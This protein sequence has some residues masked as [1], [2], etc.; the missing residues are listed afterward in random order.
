MG[1]FSSNEKEG[2]K[3]SG[4]VNS[5]TALTTSINGVSRT[6]NGSP[7]GLVGRNRQ[8]EIPGFTPNELYDGGIIP[9]K[10]NSKAGYSNDSWFGVLLKNH[11]DYSGDLDPNFKSISTSD[12]FDGSKSYPNFKDNTPDPSRFYST[13]D[14]YLLFNDTSTDYFK[15]GLHIID[16]LT[17]HRSEKN[18]RETWDGGE[19]GTPLRLSQFKGTPYENNDPVIFGFEIVIDA[20]S[21]PLL[22]GAVE[23]F[24]EQFNRIS[25]VAARKLVIADFKQQFSKIFKTRG[26]I[27]G[28]PIPPDRK[29]MSIPTANYA[30]TDS[31]TNI[32][33]PGKKAYLSYYLKKVA[34]LEFLSEANQPAKK[35]FLV[36]Y[37]NDVI[38]LTFTEDVSASLGTL[39]TLY[40]L[41]YWSKPN[42]KNIVPENLLRFNCDIIISEVRNLNRVRKAVDTGDLEVVKENVSRYIYSLKECQFWFDQ[43]FHDIEVDLS[44]IK[45]FD[46]YTLTIDFKYASQKFERWTPDIN[47]FGQYVGYNNGAIWKVGNPGGRETIGGSAS[48]ENSGTVKDVSVPK[49]YTVGVNSLKHNG[50]LA[51]IAVKSY[52]FTPA[53]VDVIK[54][55]E[56]ASKDVA[57][58]TS[59]APPSENRGDEQEGP[60]ETAEKAEKKA[61]RK[62]E[63]K[64]NFEK[65]KEA[66][67]KAGQKLAKNLEKAVL[68]EVQGQIT[69]RFRLLNNTLDKIRNAAGVGRMSDPTNIYEAPYMFQGIADAT[70]GKVSNTFF[71]DIHGSLREFAG[72]SLGSVLG[73][74]VGGMIKGND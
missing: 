20:I 69:V 67:K 16:N 34:G 61:Q 56:E 14:Y 59:G 66:S 73:G 8:R 1:I 28:D 58:D 50:V 62:A 54:T 37:R 47:G 70:G 24:I 55:A 32:F 30:T 12:R 72:D 10:Q 52:H 23:D 7:I 26:T 63:T 19:Q 15:H 48:A 36:D 13:R 41:L 51:P 35:K 49:F 64:Q 42:A 71:F 53:P 45:E 68:N 60:N 5:L 39:G 57:K 2:S 43:P 17:P 21:S 44:A 4:A 46:N 38:K 6:E 22:N 27:K 31:Q 65:F 11:P 18:N 74:K 25:E 29:T 9:K 40:K 3:I 33:N